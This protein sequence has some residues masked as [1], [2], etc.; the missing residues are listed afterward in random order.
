MKFFESNKEL[1]ANL[2]AAQESLKDANAKLAE[3]E[4][5]AEDIKA[6]DEQIANQT[7]KITELQEG[8]DELSAIFENYKTESKSKISQLEGELAEQKEA[9]EKAEN[10]AEAKAKELVASVGHKG[11]IVPEKE[12]G[13]KKELSREEFN[14]LS[15]KEKSLFCISGGKIK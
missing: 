1:K 14:K 8:Q 4:N 7:L 15:A 12:E 10:S 3:L 2:E 11:N 5:A 13:G 9:T 6:K